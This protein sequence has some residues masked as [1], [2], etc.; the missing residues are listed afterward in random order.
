MDLIAEVKGEVAQVSCRT[1][2]KVC[3]NEDYFVSHRCRGQE[4]GKKHR[5]ICNTCGKS[6]KQKIGLQ[7]HNIYI[8]NG[9]RKA[10]CPHCSYRAPDKAKLSLHLRKH[11]KAR[12]F[13]CE[14]CNASF[15]V[16]STYKTHVA[17]HSNSGK[18][19]CIHCNKAF[20]MLS[21]Y[22]EH[23]QIHNVERPFAC[24]QCGMTFKQ[25]KRLRVHLR[26]VH[27]H[28]KRFVCT[29]CGSA[30][31]NNWNLQ[32]HMKTHNYVSIGYPNVC[33]HCGSTFRGKAGL[34]AHMRMRHPMMFVGMSLNSEEIIEHILDPS[35]PVDPLKVEVF[36][37]SFCGLPFESFDLLT[38]HTTT[39]HEVFIYSSAT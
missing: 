10:A 9:E 26:A 14:I 36:S 5:F 33:V 37:C 24:S 39:E 21:Q 6:F 19:V 15:K 31:I 7:Y 22:E 2:R 25:K 34:A 20:V 27:Y 38:E 29:I 4:T 12:P 16:R 17:R 1:C 13:V 18:H 23:C 30:H 3:L 35:P 11:S 8:H 32:I 28:D